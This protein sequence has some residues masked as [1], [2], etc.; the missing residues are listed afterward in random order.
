MLACAGLPTPRT[1]LNT[2]QTK[3]ASQPASHPH[4][5]RRAPERDLGPINPRQ[6][7]HHQTSREKKFEKEPQELTSFKKDL[8]S[9]FY[10]PSRLH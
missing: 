1:T 5:R 6:R 10:I 4:E 8:L 2:K 7:G 9:S 3:S